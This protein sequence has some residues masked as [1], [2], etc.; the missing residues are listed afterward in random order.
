MIELRFE[1]ICFTLFKQSKRRKF[2]DKGS[3]FINAQPKA[4]NVLL[5]N[6][7]ISYYTEL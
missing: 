6:F 5:Y 3:K 4:K 7:S 2:I 1:I